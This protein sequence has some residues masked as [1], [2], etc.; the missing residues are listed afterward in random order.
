MNYGLRQRL[1]QLP[2]ARTSSRSSSPR[3]TP[4]RPPG[5]HPG[6]LPGRRMRPSPPV[7]ARSPGGEAT[8]PA[9]RR[10]VVHSPPVPTDPLPTTTSAPWVRRLSRRQRLGGGDGGLLF[11]LAAPPWERRRWAVPLLAAG[12]LALL[13]GPCRARHRDTRP[14][15]RSVEAAALLGLVGWRGSVVG[16]RWRTAV[17]AVAAGLAWGGGGRG[18]LFRRCCVRPPAAVRGRGRLIW[19]AGVFSLCTCGPTGWRRCRWTL[20]P[21][22]CCRG[23]GTL[24]A[25]GR[26][27]PSRTLLPTSWR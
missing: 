3:T 1:P 16:G 6:R 21:R 9:M 7:R 14:G 10:A 11:L 22:C 23:S 25:A 8:R 13:I 27:R 20:G 24:P 15:R 4:L 5:P 2:Q 12:Y 17:G 18:A 19:S 26:F